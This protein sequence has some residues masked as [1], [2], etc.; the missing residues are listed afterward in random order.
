MLLPGARR[1]VNAAAR[2]DVCAVGDGG[3]FIE[4]PRRA[5][6]EL[7]IPG[8]GEPEGVHGH[9]GRRERGREVERA[10]MWLR[11]ACRLGRT[12]AGPV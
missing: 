1:G 6:G 12:A 3:G 8:L 11:R 7:R 9:A 5:R 10:M 4:L 2:H